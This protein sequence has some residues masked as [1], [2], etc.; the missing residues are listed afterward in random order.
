MRGSEA[1]LGGGTGMKPSVG[2]RPR[3]GTAYLRL[4]ALIVFLCI[5]S[6]IAALFGTSLRACSVPVFRY[7][8]ERWPADLYDIVVFH[9]GPLAPGDRAALAELEKSSSDAPY[10]NLEVT[11]VDLAGELEEPTQKLWETQAAPEPPWMVVRYPKALETEQVVWSGPLGAPAVETLL[12]S[13]VRREIAR[14]IL[15]GDAAVWILLESGN[16]KGDDAAA[17]LLQTQLKE[18]E[19]NL[20]L[21]EFFAEDFGV[22]PEDVPELKISF[23]IVRVSRT[24]PAEQMLVKMLLGPDPELGKL[25]EP[26]A[27]PVFG[28]GRL[29]CALA[30]EQIDEEN[31]EAVCAFLVGPCSCQ[32]KAMNPGVDLLMS[33]DWDGLITG[34]LAIDEALP[35]LT[36]LPELAGLA[37]E[38]AERPDGA[39]AGEGQPEEGPGSLLRN[40]LILAA[41]GLAG[42][43]AGTF[44]LM[45]RRR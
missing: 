31:V 28:R 41:L 29:L 4:G 8:L 15:R 13:P 30:G 11:T 35:P 23:S 37:A 27:F 44:V 12:D 36:G 5:L 26:V 16:K 25:A 43:A 18:L 21:P 42:V 22:D 7:A 39:P 19:K 38:G 17:G 6:C 2:H 32:V 14:R 10:A 33:V 1:L 40:V 34:E 20:R 9:R 3:Q 45:R 24:D